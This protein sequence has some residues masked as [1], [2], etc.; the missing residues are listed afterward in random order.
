MP[1]PSYNSLIQSFSSAVASI[2]PAASP[3]QVTQPSPPSVRQG[4]GCPAGRPSK[5]EREGRLSSKHQLAPCGAQPRK[6]AL[7]VFPEVSTV[8][9]SH[10]LCWTL[11]LKRLRLTQALHTHLESFPWDDFLGVGEFP[12]SENV[13]IFKVWGTYCSLPLQKG[14]VLPRA[15]HRGSPPHARAGPSCFGTQG[16]LR[17]VAPACQ[18]LPHLLEDT[19]PCAQCLPH[20]DPQAH[21]PGGGGRW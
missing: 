13:A 20:G 1:H 21:P 14:R 10:V 12:G 11:C 4:G 18:T 3:E 9:V 6:S 16:L 5:A 15:R 8:T 2:T 17:G 7:P 19:L